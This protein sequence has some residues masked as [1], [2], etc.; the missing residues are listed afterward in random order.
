MM[1]Q[2][3]N[4][5]HPTL[6][7]LEKCQTL[8][9][10][11]QVHAHMLT[12]GLALHTYPLSRLLLFSS[13]VSIAY[14]F[15]IFNQ[16]PNPTI[17]LFNTLISSLVTNGGHNTYSVCSL[18]NRVLSHQTLKPNSF[19]F[20]S[21]F[22]AFGSDPW[23][24]HGRALHTHVLKFLGSTH[25]HFVQASLLNFYAKCGRVGVSRYLFDQI[26]EPDLASWN[27]IL[28]A[29]AHSTST[30]CISSASNGCDSSL[31]LEALYL[32]KDMQR[33][34][35]RPNE[36]S[37]VALVSACANLGALIQG[38]WA[39]S[40]A[41]RN[42]LKL[43]RFV[44]T[45]LMDMY[46]RCGCLDLAHQLFDQ[47]NERDALCYNA[48]I[49]GFAINGYGHRALGLYEKMKIEG[50]VPDDVT[51]V[52]TMCA[53]SHAGLVEEGCKVFESMEEVYGIK[54]KLEHYG[55]LVDLLGRAGRLKE[56]EERIQ[57]MPM[58]PN[59]ILWRSLLGAASVHGNLEIGEV[60][61]KNLIQLEPESSGNYVLLSNMYASIDR[62]D[63][64]NR[65]RKLMKDHGVNKMPGS[66]LV[67]IGVPCMS[68]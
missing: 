47:L 8:H 14:A 50:I 52:V 32:F 16:I 13:A 30:E 38:T 10:I 29:Y 36:V 26:R 9:A 43:N 63:D 18:Y 42:N 67:E 6:Q 61:L 3:P 27:S 19:T 45:A 46:S 34:S 11:K 62:W 39:H 65:V 53:C 33:S 68:S 23:F 66:S 1:S 4:F 12:T 35:V 41:L 48:I 44:G 31:S 37:I 55:C 60:A 7:L 57:T 40:Y 2:N 15:S 49:G 56:A 58:K 64:V 28:A 20:P 22:K 5:K 21:L 25:D 54:P 59:A 24:Q 51:F 17:F